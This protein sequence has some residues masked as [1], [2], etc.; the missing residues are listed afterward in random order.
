MGRRDHS[1]E[2]L[3]D[4]SADG[5]SR[6]PDDEHVRHMPVLFAIPTPG[7]TV[8]MAF[9]PQRHETFKN[10]DVLNLRVRPTLVYKYRPTDTL[11][12]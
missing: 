2:E 1:H 9:L 12:C 7:A 11:T 10:C 5:T 8:R 6:S 3:T 4:D